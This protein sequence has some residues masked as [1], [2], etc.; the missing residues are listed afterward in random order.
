ME[1]PIDKTEMRKVNKEGVVVDICPN[2]KG[3]WLDRGELDKIIA[4][5]SNEIEHP[6]YPDRKR[7]P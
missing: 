4:L 1:C 6:G 5:G 7:Y 3:V 2:C